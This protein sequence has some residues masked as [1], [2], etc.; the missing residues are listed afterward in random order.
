MVIEWVR[1]RDAS[2]DRHLRTYLF[3]EGSIVGREAA[4]TGGDGSAVG[5]PATGLGLGSLKDE[6]SS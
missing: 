4:A 2:F 3:T 6:R 1:R 5:G